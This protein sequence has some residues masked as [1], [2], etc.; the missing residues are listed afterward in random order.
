MVLTSAAAL[1]GLLALG[2][3]AP[4]F[5]QGAGSK[6]A[7]PKAAEPSKPAAPAQPGAAAPSKPGQPGA[8]AKAP[9][10]KQRKDEALK[11]YKQAEAKFDKG[12]CAGA[13]PLYR[14]AD[15]TY[16]GAAPKYKI[17]VCLDKGGQVIDAVAA[18]QAYLDSKPDPKEH[19]D[20]MADAQKR[21]EELKKTPAKVKVVTV[22][23][24]A[25]NLQITIDGVPQPGHDL[26]LTPGKHQLALK[27][28]GFNPVHEEITVSFAETRELSIPLT[29]Q[30]APPPPPPIAEAPPP[31]P[32]P[33]APLPPPAPPPEPSSPIPAYISWGVAGAGLAVG[34]IFGI[35]ALGSKSTYEQDMTMENLDAIETQ[36]T[37]AD[38]GFASAI[39]FGLVGTVLFFNSRPAEPA[40]ARVVR[41]GSTAFVSPYV[42]PNGGGAAARLTF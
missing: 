9:S 3:V 8:G 30:A 19:K 24:A 34:T 32:P 35:M 7:Q 4:A 6:P 13:L 17:A 28:D 42:G 39:G 14:Q 18:Y 15:A 40:K 25:P 20:K 5:A 26:S 12:D 10:E 2:S 1:S 36:A 31:A 22:P 37:I 41:P 27:A 33:A 38:I 21:I 16:P 11:S 29:A 23:A